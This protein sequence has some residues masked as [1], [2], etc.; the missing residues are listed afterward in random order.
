MAR[1]I[2]P[3]QIKHGD[4]IRLVQEFTVGKSSGEVKGSPLDGDGEVWSRESNDYVYVQDDSFTIELVERP[5]PPLPDVWGSVVKVTHS[6]SGVSAN[7]LLHNGGQ[8]V[9]A[10]GTRKTS[11]D[12]LRWMQDYG[13]TF[14]VLG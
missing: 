14:E 3:E 6:P 5:L 11:E 4:K 1:I 13:Y 12:L 8:W 2:T 10:S 7:W 9:S